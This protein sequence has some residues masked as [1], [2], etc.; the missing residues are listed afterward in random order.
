MVEVEGGE[1]GLSKLSLLKASW[2]RRTSNHVDLDSDYCGGLLVL[3]DAG[4]DLAAS[5]E[6]N[7]PP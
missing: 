1:G 2:K 7:S 6:L 3:I 4:S 5:E